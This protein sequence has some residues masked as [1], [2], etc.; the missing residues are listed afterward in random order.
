MRKKGTRRRV[1]R[2]SL[3]KAKT[4]GARATEGRRN[5]TVSPPPPPPPR[6]RF[7]VRSSSRD[8]STFYHALLPCH[9]RSRFANRAMLLHRRKTQRRDAIDTSVPES[10][11]VCRRSIIGARPRERPRRY[12]ERGEIDWIVSSPSAGSA[13]PVRDRLEVTPNLNP[14]NSR[15][16]GRGRGKVERDGRRAKG[17]KEAKAT[18]GA[19]ASRRRSILPDGGLRF[20]FF[21]FFFLSN[22]G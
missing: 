17:L 15:W 21:F 1:P 8:R 3:R 9:S 19:Y 5:L 4:R 22:R 6:P 16:R 13:S 18:A 11:A 20:I 14:V 10:S 12:R 2:E 7:T